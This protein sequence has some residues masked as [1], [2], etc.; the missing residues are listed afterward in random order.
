MFR[1]AGY[2]CSLI[3]LAG[4]LGAASLTGTI[5]DASGAVVPN[6]ALTLAGTDGSTQNATAG[7]AGQFSFQAAPGT[8]RLE[9]RSPGFML[10]NSNVRL[11][12]DR[13]MPVFLRVGMV[14]ETLEVAASGS[15]QPT[16]PR[17]VRVGGNVTPVKALSM[18]RP[19]YPAS[20]RE[21]GIQGTVTLRC[22]ILKDG[23]PAS[24]TPALDTD[25]ELIEAAT[26]TVRQWRYQP[27]L[28]NGQPVETEALVT[29]NYKLQ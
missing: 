1:I 26:A 19:V 13:V 23:S 27:A 20:A 17:R 6:A 10:L 9:V 15:P 3:A 5:Y 11:E 21:R 2:V 25:P 14:T 22:V 28:L 24:I 4:G 12:G 29:I 8:Y 7:E 16:P 18:T